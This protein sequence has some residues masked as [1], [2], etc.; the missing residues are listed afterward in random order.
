MLLILVVVGGL[1]PPAADPVVAQLRTGLNVGGLVW[2]TGTTALTIAAVNGW[3]GQRGLGVAW[4][5]FLFGVL[6]DLPGSP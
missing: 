5:P 1:S 2:S 3:K 6:D 4:V